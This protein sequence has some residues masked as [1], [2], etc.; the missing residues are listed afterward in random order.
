MIILS[1]LMYTGNQTTILN[2][3]S[4]F[5]KPKNMEKVVNVRLLP[6]AVDSGIVFKRVDLKENNA[7]KVSYSNA[8]IEGNELVL[9]N[10]SGVFVKHVELLLAG[11]WSSKIDNL[12]V[13]IDGDSVPYIDGTS[14][15]ISFLLSV[16]KTK[17]LEKSRKVF[18]TAQDIGMRI[19][20]F[21][22]SIKP[23]KSFIID[24]KNGDSQFVFDNGIYPYKDWLSRVNEDNGDSAKCAVISTIAIIFISNLFCTFNVE[25]KNFDKKM[26]FDFFK[27]LLND[28]G[29]Q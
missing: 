9:K 16:G 17:E 14:E 25:I 3:V 23:D 28:K 2:E 29:N 6:A 20:D 8:F 22:I 10:D 1:W 7:I 21:E 15:P 11:I 24:V 27:N 5:G 12:I 26:T 18:E 13:E 4:F 19:S